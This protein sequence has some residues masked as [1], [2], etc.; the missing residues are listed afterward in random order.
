[1]KKG[2]DEEKKNENEKEKDNESRKKEIAKEFLS[3]HPWLSHF[4]IDK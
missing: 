3:L 4:K 1:M 2:R